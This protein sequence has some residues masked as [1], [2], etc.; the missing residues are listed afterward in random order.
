MKILFK[1]GALE[2]L[3]ELVRDPLYKSSALLAFINYGKIL[4]KTDPLKTIYFKKGHSNDLDIPLDM[5]EKITFILDNGFKLYIDKKKLVEKSNVF[6]TM[7]NS[8][9]LEEKGIVHLHDVEEESVKYFFK[10]LYLD[11]QNIDEINPPLPKTLRAAV[12][13]LMLTDKYLLDDLNSVLC[14]IIVQFLLKPS[15]ICEIYEQSSYLRTENLKQECLAHILNNNQARQ[16]I[17]KLFS[18]SEKSE[19]VNFFVSDLEELFLQ[20]RKI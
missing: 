4:K 15:N 7:L 17:C 8:K 3:S 6:D 16:E 14:K 20:E 19:L 12:E 13:A 18:S 9:F 2:V 11:L 1:F 5:E 10:L